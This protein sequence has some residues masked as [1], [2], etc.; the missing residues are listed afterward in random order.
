MAIHPIIVEIF[1]SKAQ[2]IPDNSHEGMA[3]VSRFPMNADELVPTKYSIFSI[4]INQCL[5]FSF[6]VVMPC[7]NTGE[8]QDRGR[9][10]HY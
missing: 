3:R 9:T 10:N 1:Q 8:E 2:F 5:A 6:A 4:K 7:Q